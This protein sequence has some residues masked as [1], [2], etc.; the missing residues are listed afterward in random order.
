MKRGRARA[1][2]S[3][4]P[5]AGEGPDEALDEG[6]TSAAGETPDPDSG[7]ARKA[8]AP[9]APP[10]DL[11]DI[12]EPKASS[13]L[14][15][16][17]PRF[18]FLKTWRWLDAVAVRDRAADREKGRYDWAPVWALCAG[19][20]CLTLMEYF[21]GRRDFER[22]LMQGFKVAGQLLIDPRPEVIESPYYELYSYIYW[23]GWRFVGYFVLPAIV[24]KVAL[25]ARIRDFGLETKGFVEHAWIYVVFFFIVLGP[26]VAVSYTRSFQTHYPFYDLAHRSWFDFLAWEVFYALQFFSLEFFFRGFLVHALRKS[27]GSY[28]I[29]AM[30]AP[31]CMI[32]FGKPILETLGAILAGVALGTLALRTRSIWA[33]FLIHVSVAVTMDVASLL[34]GRG[35]PSVFWPLLR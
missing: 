6:A 29:F 21:G 3:S 4:G 8:K 25:R 16:L 34:H 15:E 2:A 23:S 13:K 17:D 27:M 7:A 31:Y 11:E 12:P 35:L 32:H 1:V 5:S 26:L 22:I 10:T 19:A 30:V 24:V 9:K 28:A 33:G 14:A 20:V 18:F